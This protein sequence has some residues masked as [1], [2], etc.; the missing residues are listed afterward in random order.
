MEIDIDVQKCSCHLV[1]GHLG[2]V[3]ELIA[4]LSKEG[5]IKIWAK[6]GKQRNSLNNIKNYQV[7]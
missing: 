6:M 1:Y 7:V 4:V 3:A 2:H 5:N